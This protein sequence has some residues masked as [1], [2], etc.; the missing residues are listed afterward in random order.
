MIACIRT[1]KQRA[2]LD[3]TTHR[4]HPYSGV[5]VCAIC[6]AGQPRDVAREESDCSVNDGVLGNDENDAFDDDAFDEAGGKLKL[7]FRCVLCIPRV[8]PIVHR[9]NG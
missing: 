3:I 4:F 9:K 1:T 7:P 2:Q 6:C 8:F 5:C